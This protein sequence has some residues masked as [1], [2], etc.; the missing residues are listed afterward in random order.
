MQVTW[1]VS[2][3]QDQQEPYH[4]IAADL[5]Q[6]V[7]WVR[8]QRQ[9]RLR[10]RR[11]LHVSVVKRALR[12]ARRPPVQPRMRRL[13]GPG[14]TQRLR[15]LVQRRLRRMRVAVKRAAP[16]G[17]ERVPGHIMPAAHLQAQARQVLLRKARKGSR[18]R[19]PG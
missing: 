14:R 13:R 3:S 19:H 15:R 17:V 9:L 6:V 2:L 7:A 8:D 12:G 11:R 10:L 18:T 16:A 4:T 1:R 5:L